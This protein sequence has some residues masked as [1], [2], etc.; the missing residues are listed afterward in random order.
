MT[1]MAVPKITGP[2]RSSIALHLIQV[3]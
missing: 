2:E 3:P 1:S